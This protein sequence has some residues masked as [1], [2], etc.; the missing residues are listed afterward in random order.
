MLRSLGLA[1]GR[2][3]L[4]WLVDNPE[5]FLF[6]VVAHDPDFVSRRV[7]EW[8][9]YYERNIYPGRRLRMV[10]GPDFRDP[11]GRGLVFFRLRL[12]P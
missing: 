8:L 3:F 4:R 12:E 11:S 2:A 1:D 7:D 10:P 5:V 6:Q 9:G